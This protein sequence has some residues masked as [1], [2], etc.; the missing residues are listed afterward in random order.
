MSLA[1]F[2]ALSAPAFLGLLGIGYGLFELYRVRRMKAEA[3]TAKTA[4]L[5]AAHPAASGKSISG[6]F[7][8][9]AVPRNEDI[10]PFKGKRSFEVQDAVTLQN[11]VEEAQR[12][13]D[14][15]MDVLKQS[16]PAQEKR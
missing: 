11:Q 8:D 4:E 15:A 6:G 2:Y 13:L 12:Y 5:P 7:L 10:Q 9:F 16:E 3:A 14:R 1:Q